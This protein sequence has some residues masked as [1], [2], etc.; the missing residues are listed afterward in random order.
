MSLTDNTK[1]KLIN[2]LSSTPPIFKT[3]IIIIEELT[4]GL[5]KFV[6]GK[7][8]L[9]KDIRNSVKV[10]GLCIN[11]MHIVINGLIGWIEKL[12]AP[13][14][15]I[16]TST[17]RDDFMKMYTPRDKYTFDKMM[18]FTIKFLD[19]YYTHMEK[20]YKEVWD[21]RKRLVNGD[22]VI[23]PKHRKVYNDIEKQSGIPSNIKSGR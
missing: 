6:P 1:E 2:E 23:P 11:T 9:H 5:C 7:P 14:Y 12:H 16:V 18:C 4:T 15:D 19:E 21:A 3:I 17:W 20:M 8:L 10:D 22:N 13:V